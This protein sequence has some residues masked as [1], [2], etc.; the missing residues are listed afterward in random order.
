MKAIFVELPEAIQPVN[1]GMTRFL[2][3]GDLKVSVDGKVITVPSKFKTDFASV[4]R[5]FRWLIPPMGRYSWAAV[6]H[7]YLLING[8]DRDYAR[9]VFSACLVELDS[10]AW[11]RAL[12]VGGVWLWDKTR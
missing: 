11:R 7:D 5:L 12:L 4:P 3:L 6:V 9:A 8:Y 2:T 10:R 1:I